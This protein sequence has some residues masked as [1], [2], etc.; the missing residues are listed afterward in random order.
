MLEDV[1]VVTLLLSCRSELRW[2]LCLAFSS[3]RTRVTL[4]LY[5]C[6]LHVHWV[7][8]EKVD[9]EADFDNSEAYE[10]KTGQKAITRYGKMVA[11]EDGDMMTAQT[12]LR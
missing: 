3:F 11:C 6:S 1:V 12:R 2:G 4:G 9:S 10:E 8:S 7:G 5:Y